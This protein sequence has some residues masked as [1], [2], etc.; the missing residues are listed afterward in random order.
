[1]GAR[2]RDP[3]GLLFTWPAPGTLLFRACS[4]LL[5]E[6]SSRSF[7]SGAHP[8]LE[9]LVEHDDQSEGAWVWVTKGRAP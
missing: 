4:P 2:A 1:M 3:F 7:L 6:Q 8:T 9:L 5:A